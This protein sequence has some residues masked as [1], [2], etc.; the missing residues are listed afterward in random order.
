MIPEV[1]ESLRALLLAAV[2]DDVTIGIEPDGSDVVA[3]LTDLRED[4]MGLP[5]NWEELRDERGVVVARRPPI[6][7][8]ELRY[9]IT[10]H[11]DS[12]AAAHALF[13]AMLGSISAIS[14]IDPPYRHDHFADFPILIRTAEPRPTMTERPLSLDVIITA[15]M[16]LAWTSD[17]APPPDEF[18]LGA[19]RGASRPTPPDTRPP[20]PLRARRAREG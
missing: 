14:S 11:A 6:R 10:T 19:S 5:A 18:T 16:L 3:T 13:D 2:P 17:V 12:S 15:P 9:T 1:D 8:Y 4:T 7:R 20:R